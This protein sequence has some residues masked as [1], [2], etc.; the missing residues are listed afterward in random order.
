MVNAS[1]AMLLAASLAHVAA[2]SPGPASSAPSPT[3]VDSNGKKVDWWFIYKMPNGFEYAYKEAGDNS[4]TSLNVTG[5]KLDN[6]VNNALAATLHQIYIA[7]KSERLGYALYNDED[8][9]NN[10]TTSGSTGHTK[11]V[12]AAGASGSGFWLIHS[13]PK[14]PELTGNQFKWQA[15]NKFGQ[16][17]LCITLDSVGMEAAAMQEMYTVPHVFDQHMPTKVAAKLPSLALLA[18]G[19]RI[20]HKKHSGRTSVAHIKSQT[21][22]FTHFAKT[23]KYGKDFYQDLVAPHLNTDLYV[24]TWRREPFCGT[25]CA[26]KA[27]ATKALPSPRGVA[28]GA[29]GGAYSIMNVQGLS[30]GD[31]HSF[32]YRQDHSKLA[33][34]A[35]ADKPFVCVGGVNRMQSQRKRG[36]GTACIESLHLWSALAPVFQI[37]DKCDAFK[38]LVL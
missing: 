35:S 2:Q 18:Q 19:K 21:A 38:P 15:S 29:G 20:K 6:I 28:A 22:T 10:A 31:T 36:G 7:K 8:P 37:V 9:I 30:F 26:P 25:Y 34:S 1:V 5:A 12:L 24:E 13:V 23:P 17:M 11:G 4:T 16:S 27:N 3:C 32:D 14:F 33:V